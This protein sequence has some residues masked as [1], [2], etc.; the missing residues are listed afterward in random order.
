MAEWEIE[1]AISGSITVN[2][3]LSLDVTKG[4]L[5]PFQTRA[6]IQRMPRNVAGVNIRVIVRASDQEEAN[7]AAVYFI[8]QMLDVLSLRTDLPL[9]V[10]LATTQT[11]SFDSATRQIPL[12]RAYRNDQ[13]SSVALSTSRFWN[14]GT[15]RLV[16]ESEWEEAFRLGREYGLNWPVFSRALSWYRK[17]LAS[18]DP[19][20]KLIAYWSSLESVGS[21]Y[22]RKNSRTKLGAINQVC[23]CF[24]QI[25]GKNV[26][27]WPVISGNT[28]WVNKF[29]EQRNGIAHG[30]VPVNIETLRDIV[31]QLPKLRELSYKFLTK[32]EIDGV[33]IAAPA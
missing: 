31:A 6:S 22:A 17:G 26:K 24:E 30:F 7:D 3:P 1:L 13:I 27:T 14:N 8:G 15:K 25:W 33:D 4:R 16:N 2:H 10:N 9:V 20:D 19:I 11:I 21:H 29:H 12:G 23:D 28:K 5:A 32:W 18:E